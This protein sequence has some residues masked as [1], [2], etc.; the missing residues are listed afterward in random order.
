MT[1]E[2]F[3]LL[4]KYDDK[5]ESIVA[6]ATRVKYATIQMQKECGEVFNRVFG[7]VIPQ[8][9]WSCPHCAFKIYE[10]LAKD[11]VETKKSLAS[12][13]EN[14]EVKKVRKNGKRK[15]V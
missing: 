13:E 1:K 8:G 4:S 6:G 2:D 12:K 9:E 5:F 11:Y 7:R 15:E 3:E 10:Q 14:K